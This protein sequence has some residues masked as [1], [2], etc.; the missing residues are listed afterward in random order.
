[1]AA[2]HSRLRFLHLAAAG[3]FFQGG[4]AAVDTG[5]IVAALS[6]TGLRHAETEI[7]KWRAETGA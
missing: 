3:I 1:M 7:G 2:A 4:A 5:T 6:A